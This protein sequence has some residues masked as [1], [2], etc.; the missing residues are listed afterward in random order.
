MRKWLARLFAGKELDAAWAAVEDAKQEAATARL[1][2][3]YVTV[4]TFDKT[5][6]EYMVNIAGLAQNEF[7]TFF[8]ADLREQFIDEAAK[9]DPE[10]AKQWLGMIKGLENVIANIKAMPAVIAKVTAMREARG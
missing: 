9:S 1:R 7:F 10:S 5:D 2:Q 6:M 8:M 3:K 4:K